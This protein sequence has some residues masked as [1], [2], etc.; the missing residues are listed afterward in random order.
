MDIALHMA[1]TFTFF[2]NEVDAYVLPTIKPTEFL[3]EN[4]KNLGT[5]KYKI[6]LEAVRLI[7]SEFLKIPISISTLDTK[8]EYKSRI[9]GRVLKDS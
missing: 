4:Y 6:Y 8:L 1:L 2:Y 5:E 9:K 7:W 3:F